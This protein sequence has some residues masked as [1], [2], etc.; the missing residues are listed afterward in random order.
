MFRKFAAIGVAAAAALLFTTLAR[1]S[2]DHALLM[3]AL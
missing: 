1:V 2:D 3:P